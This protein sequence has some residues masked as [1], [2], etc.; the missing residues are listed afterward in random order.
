M[1]SHE[2]PIKI[3]EKVPL[4]SFEEAHV[5]TALCHTVSTPML[6]EHNTNVSTFFIGFKYKRMGDSSVTFT[7]LDTI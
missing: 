3:A 2:S 4:L 5:N 7:N 6:L 1:V